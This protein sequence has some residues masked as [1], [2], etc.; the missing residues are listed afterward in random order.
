MIYAL[1][2]IIF[3]FLTSQKA[4]LR[5]EFL[6]ITHI[7]CLGFTLFSDNSLKFDY[8]VTRN[9]ICKILYIYVKL[10]SMNSARKYVSNHA[11]HLYI[12]QFCI[13]SFP[14]LIDLDDISYF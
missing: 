3:L 10:S 8:I 2:I 5:Y 4:S 9:D 12:I 13:K 7:C 11:S 6:A 14:F 1:S